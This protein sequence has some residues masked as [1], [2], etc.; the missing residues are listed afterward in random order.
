MIVDPKLEAFLAEAP[1]FLQPWWLEAVAPGKWDYVVVKRGEEIA[2]T[3]PF[4]WKKRLGRA[5]I[6][7]PQKSPYMG[8]WLRK[9][10]AKYANRLGEEKELVTEL[11]EGLPSHVAF[12][13]SFHP[14][15]TNWLPFH[16]KG[17]HQTTRY[18]YRFSE[19]ANLED[20]WK[21]SRENVRTDI[22][23]ARKTLTLEECDDFSTV[24][25][26]HKLTCERQGF[27][28]AYSDQEMMALHNACLNHECSKVVI[29]RDEENRPHAAA[30]FVWDREVLYYFTSGAD[31]ALRNSGAGSLLI[32][33]GIEMASRMNK[34]FDFEG[35]ME[36]PIE[37][38]FRAFGARQTPYFCVNRI[39]QPRIAFIFSFLQRLSAKANALKAGAKRLFQINSTN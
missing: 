21:E 23:K 13:Q 29:A 1:L 6:E 17:F 19:T 15:I 24:L 36:E 30:Y 8:P 20:L 5:Y 39:S 4:V 38:F 14:G 12:T 22:K 32:W 34:G 27:R 28:F 25:R 11:I 26:L 9:S 16:W 18:T 33:A 35:S 10:S 37:R 3:M 31:P 7:G 2:A